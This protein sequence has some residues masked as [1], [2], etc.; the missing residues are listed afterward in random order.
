MAEEYQE[1]PQAPDLFNHPVPSVPVGT[2]M[3]NEAPPFDSMPDPIAPVYGDSDVGTFH[4]PVYNDDLFM[5]NRDENMF[6]IVYNPED[7]GPNAAVMYVAGVIVSGSAVFNI[8]GAPGNSVPVSSGER[9]PLDDDII[10]YLNV[11]ADDYNLSMV[12]SEQSPD[13][14]FSLPLARTRRG[15]NGYIQQLHRGA[16]FIGTEFYFGPS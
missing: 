4:T 13:A 2:A 3:F 8:G 1:I 12:S 16:V 15:T 14:F 5:R 11:N 9:A 7:S 6:A 10:W